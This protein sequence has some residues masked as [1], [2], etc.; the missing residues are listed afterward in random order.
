MKD[1]K[2]MNKVKFTSEELLS[3]VPVGTSI[4]KIAIPAIA[5]ML[6]MAIYNFVD[7]LFIGMLNDPLALSAVGIAFPIMTLLG[8]LGQV[9][10]AGAAASIGRYFGCGDEDRANKTASTIVFT[11][12]VVAILFTLFGMMFNE[13]IFRMFGASEAT[14]PYAK[15]YGT[16]MFIGAIFSIPNQVF[17]NIARAETKA[18]L[19]MMALMTGAIANIILDPIFMFDFGFGLGIEGASIATTISQGISF[20][21]ISQ[22]F[23]RGK[24]RAKVK[25][26]FFKPSKEIYG[27]TLKSGAPVG[28][29]QALSTIAVLTTN[30]VAL[31]T[32]STPV[33]ADNLIAAYGVV[34]KV[35]SMTQMT[36]MGYLQG[37]QPL[38]SYSYGAKNKER[39]YLSY[40][41][42]LKFVMIY[43]IVITVFVQIF[44]PDIIMMFSSDPEIILFGTEFLRKTNM[45][46]PLTGFIFFIMLTFQATGN[47]RDGAIIA[48]TRQG[49][50]YMLFIISFPIFMGIS[51]MYYSQPAADILT[52]ILAYYL[53]KRNR[54][55]LDKHFG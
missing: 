20:L 46:F 7:T 39:F 4:R 24:S 6:I 40:K 31:N 5:G 28:V 22:Y 34:L 53:F 12:F 2:K 45:F 27:E 18:K 21:F 25:F 42:A 29:T 11:S 51:G 33:Q 44:A 55:E 19:S 36:L 52:T 3:T 13:E 26:K 10:G 41:Y 1:E 54:K 50:L 48:M 23:F 14:M 15:S 16:W 43:T 37:Y 17:N 9:M 49:I 38:A 30:R 8:A 35:L 47:G 32:A